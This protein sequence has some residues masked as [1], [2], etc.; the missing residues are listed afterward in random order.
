MIIESIKLK[1]KK[2]ANIFNVVADGNTFV[3][4]SDAIVK[5]GIATNKEVEAGQFFK[6][7]KESDYIICLNVATNYMGSRLRTLKQLKDYLTTKGF[8]YETI[9]I[10]LEKLGEYKVVNDEEFS[11]SFIKVNSTKYSKKMIQQ[12][13]QQKGV[14]KQDFVESLQEIDDKETCVHF[15][16]S[17]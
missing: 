17:F 9:N 13:L 11:K 5:F 2:N 7:V 6:A 10:V 8:N 12:K 16:K 4:H 1:S 14:K 15:A 3:L